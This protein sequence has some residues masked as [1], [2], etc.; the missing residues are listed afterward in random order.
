MKTGSGYETNGTYIKYK[1]RYSGKWCVETEFYSKA[2]DTEI[3]AD[4]YASGF[5]L[6]QGVVISQYQPHKTCD[7]KL[8]YSS[9]GKFM[10]HGM[11]QH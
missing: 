4:E 8:Q 9:T 7:C 1:S 6:P 3:E 2:F 5:I 11:C 10:C